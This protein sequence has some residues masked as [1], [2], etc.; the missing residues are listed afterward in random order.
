MRGIFKLNGEREEERGR[1]IKGKDSPMK[2]VM[3]SLLNYVY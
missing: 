2:E 1:Y 3:N